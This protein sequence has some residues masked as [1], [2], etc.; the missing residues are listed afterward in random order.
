MPLSYA[1]A[2]FALAFVAGIAPAKA[3]TFGSRLKQWQKMGFPEG[4]NVGRGV[5]AEYGARQIYQLMF[6]LKLMRVGLTPQRAQRVVIDAWPRLQDAIIETASC[7][8][9]QAEHI[10]Y[11]LIQLNALSDLGEGDGDHMHIFADVFTSEEIGGSFLPCDNSNASEDEVLAAKMNDFYVKNRLAISISVEVDSMLILLWSAFE[12]SGVPLD[13]FADEMRDWYD[14]RSAR[15]R[16]A[17]E[18]EY[19]DKDLA[20]RSLAQF[21]T[22]FNATS[23]ARKMLSK[24]PRDSNPQA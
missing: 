1:Q 18:S 6:M 4:I 12:V 3:E 15:G 7:I 8:A 16:A 19:F 17:I 20:A 9:I 2:S 5:K 14:E 22:S 21:N 24:V 11:C 23:A 10:H 13:I